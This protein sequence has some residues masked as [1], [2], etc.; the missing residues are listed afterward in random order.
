MELIEAE[1]CLSCGHLSFCIEPD[2][3]QPS[4]ESEENLRKVATSDELALVS[5]LADLRN[6][7]RQL[8]DEINQVRD[9]L[10]AS[11]FSASRELF[12]SPTSDKPIAWADYSEQYWIPSSS[13][14][15]LEKKFPTVIREFFK[16]RK[17]Y[18]I[19]VQKPI[20]RG[21]YFRRRNTPS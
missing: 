4:H 8:E 7:K 3:D 10:I 17:T 21:R 20:G 19:Y 16:L 18:T 14:S 1:I 9:S 12:E 2:C 5:K 15:E 6:Q 13:I 11:A